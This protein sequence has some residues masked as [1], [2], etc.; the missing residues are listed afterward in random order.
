MGKDVPEG[1]WE[2]EDHDQDGVITWEE[3]GGPKG[4]SPEADEQQAPRH[5]SG[6][7]SEL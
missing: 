1:I 5:A 6:H 3:F 4:D 7:H 2:R